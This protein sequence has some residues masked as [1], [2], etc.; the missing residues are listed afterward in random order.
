MYQQTKRKGHRPDAPH[1]NP[2]GVNRP[3]TK[4]ERRALADLKLSAFC[5]GDVQLALGVER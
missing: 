5:A 3:L 1:Q 2:R 4:A